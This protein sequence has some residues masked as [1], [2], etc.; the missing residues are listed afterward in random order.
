MGLNMVIHPN[1][2]HP[3]IE[4]SHTK[5]KAITSRKRPRLLVLANALIYIP[6]F[7]LSLDFLMGI[8]PDTIVKREEKNTATQREK[9]KPSCLFLFSFFSL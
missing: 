2:N 8:A 3:I 6:F 4:L 5:K 1:V 7:L 9:C